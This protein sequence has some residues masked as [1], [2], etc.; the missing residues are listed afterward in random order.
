M[1]L[2]KKKYRYICLFIPSDHYV[3]PTVL[4]KKI[5]YLYLQLFGSIKF[6]TTLIK[7]IHLKNIDKRFVILKC[8]LSDLPDIL[9]SIYLTS[10][11][12]KLILFISGTL[13][14]IKNKIKSFQKLD[15]FN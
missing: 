13:K 12:T 6:H 14:S 2:K 9:L 4:I 1:A 5:C 3:D 15:I 10:C 8:G 7:Y 11:I